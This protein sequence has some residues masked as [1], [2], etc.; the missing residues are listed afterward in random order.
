M[1]SK[2]NS[3]VFSTRTSGTIIKVS[4]NEFIELI[5][6]NK[7]AAANMDICGCFWLPSDGEG[8]STL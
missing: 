1:M 5:G 4:L 6:K 3:E 8:K 7:K 2:R